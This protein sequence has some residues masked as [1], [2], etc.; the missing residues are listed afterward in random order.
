MIA[1]IIASTIAH[2]F[3]AGV[4]VGGAGCGGPLG[5][6]GW[7]RGYEHGMRKVASWMRPKLDQASGD[8]PNLPPIRE[9]RFIPTTGRS[10]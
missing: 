7:C 1:D 6:I 4:V 5:I 2:P 10:S 8:I 9:R 3:L